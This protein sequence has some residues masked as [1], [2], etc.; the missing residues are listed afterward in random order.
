M[1]ISKPFQKEAVEKFY[2]IT[3]I[4]NAR[5][6]LF[7]N[8]PS[9]LP[10]QSNKFRSNIRKPRFLVLFD[11]LN[12]TTIVV[13]FTRGFLIYPL[14]LWHRFIK[15]E[16]KNQKIKGT[17]LKV[18]LKRAISFYI[19]MSN[20]W[21]GLFPHLRDNVTQLDFFNCYLYTTLGLWNASK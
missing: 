13:L 16:L 2:P 5:S 4:I 18:F 19:L 12:H 1:E 9:H 17:I 8:I 7:I 6:M 14:Y 10:R 11:N 20:V 21:D 15:V 3:I